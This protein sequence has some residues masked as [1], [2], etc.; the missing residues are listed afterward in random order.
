MKQSQVHQIMQ[1]NTDLQSVIHYMSANAKE[2]LRIPM[3]HIKYNK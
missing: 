1:I 2:R 3:R